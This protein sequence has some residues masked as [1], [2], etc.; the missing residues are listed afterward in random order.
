[1]SIITLDSEF[2]RRALGSGRED[3]SASVQV[4]PDAL[5]ADLPVHLPP[6]LNVRV[7]GSVRSVA[8]Q[9]VFFGSAVPQLPSEPVAWRVF[10]DSPGSQQEV[11]AA[12]IAS[13]TAQGWQAAHPYQQAFVEA[14][15]ADWMGV[16]PAQ[17]R[18]LTVVARG[19]GDMVQVW[20]TVQDTD[21]RQVAHLLGQQTHPHFPLPLP[22]PTLAAPEGWRVQ[23]MQG[24]GGEEE[25]SERALLLAPPET[26]V[27]VPALL[28]HFQAQL[29]AQDWHIQFGQGADL[30]A[31]TPLGLGIL[32]V[33]AH[34]QGAKVFL[35]QMTRRD[36]GSG[37][38]TSFYTL[39]S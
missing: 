23:M 7:L 39:H 3:D 26:Q 15:R 13:L 28:A 20:L 33:T 21:E 11:I 4:M 34:P 38:A 24:N 36:N 32:T 9:W 18:S 19:E 31:S 16:H 1:M 30:F 29:A 5:P 10:L 2:L 6:A 12:F 14:A 22:L 25:R 27:D 35:W 8:A 17:S 37:N